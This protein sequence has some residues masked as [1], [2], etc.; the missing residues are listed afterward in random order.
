CA[1]NYEA[2]GEQRHQSRPFYEYLLGAGNCFYLFGKRVE[3]VGEIRKQVAG[4]KAGKHGHGGR[5][6]FLAEC[7]LQKAAVEV[8]GAAHVIVEAGDAIWVAPVD[9]R[10]GC[11]TKRQISIKGCTYN[12]SKQG[13]YPG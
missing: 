3:L 12:E 13:G 10:I 6:K 1:Q 7:W 9:R 2:K 4:L 5:R 8:F 11:R